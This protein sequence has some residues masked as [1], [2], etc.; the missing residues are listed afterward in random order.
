[1]IKTK[2]NAPKI[3]RK[4]NATQTLCTSLFLCVR[5]SSSFFP[6]LANTTNKR[7]ENAKA[8]IRLG[9]SQHDQ[10]SIR[11]YFLFFGILLIILKWF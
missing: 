10:H 2:T 6:L 5:L 9:N 11:C 4:R 8:N 3:N 1:M 7:N